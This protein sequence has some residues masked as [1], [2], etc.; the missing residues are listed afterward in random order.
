MGRNFKLKFNINEGILIAPEM[1]TFVTDMN[2]F[3]LCV[4]LYKEGKTK[5]VIIKNA[6]LKDYKVELYATKPPM[7]KEY[8]V[9]EGVVDEKLNQINFPIDETFS[10]VKGQYKCELRISFGDEILTT[11]PFVYQVRGTVVEKAVKEEKVIIKE[12]KPRVINNLQTTNGE[13][14]LSAKQGYIL[15]N[16]IDEVARE[17]NNRIDSI[18]NSKTN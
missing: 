4:E 18:L 15:N 8:V 10:N 2:A 12:V 1:E 13:V 11:Q 7:L 6:E 5:S 14:A 16:K 17:L 9:C 3:S